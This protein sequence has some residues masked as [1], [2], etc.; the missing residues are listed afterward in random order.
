MTKYYTLSNTRLLLISMLCTLVC[1][2]VLSSCDLPQSLNPAPQTP[3]EATVVPTD[4]PTPAPPTATPLPRGGNLTIRL[5]QDIPFLQPWRPRTR[6]EEQII[7]LMYNGLMKLDETL[8]PQPDLAEKWEASQDGRIITFTIRSGVT[9]HDGEPM[10]AVDVHFTLDRMRALPFTTTA[11]LAD[12]RHISAIATPNRQTIVLSLTERYA[13]LLSEL[14]LPILPRHLLQEEDVGSFNFWDKPI[15]TGPFK[16]ERRDRAHSVIL[17]RNNDYYRGTP[18]LDYVAFVGAVDENLSFEAV[19]DGRLMLAE[20]HWDT[21][22]GITQTLEGLRI[23]GYPENG[24]YFLAFN[25]RQGRPFA[26]PQVRR[27]LAKAIDIPG[28]V[29]SVTKGQGIPIANSAAPGSWA[30]RTPLET[31]EPDLDGARI[32]LDDAGWT[33]ANNSTIRQW[34]GN[35]FQ[36]QIFVRGDDPR[37]IA[38]ARNIAEKAAAIGLQI[39]VQPADF[40]T[41]I[42]SKYAPPYDFDLLL[43][44]W[45]NGAGDPD[46]SDYMYYDPDDFALFHSSQINQGPMDTR[47]TRNIVGFNDPVY[48]DQAN[49]FRQIYDIIYRT[50]ALQQAQARIASLQP[51]LY[52]WADRI[53]V[54]MNERLTTLDGPINLSTPNYLWNIERWHF[55]EN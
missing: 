8:Q 4:T 34:E 3:A 44:S 36:A 18:L 16:F 20:F 47:I 41:V 22:R 12:L 48:D 14:T 35:P 6:G 26:D 2:G 46:F 49:T 55:T 9:W 10:D 38:A 30:D 21:V 29:E 33:I 32:L 31:T 51:Y 54:A 40:E 11:L 7:G 52:L 13:P 39:T 45:S 42:V 15:G 1:I 23:G 27:A 43:G 19:K 50:K 24:F 17:V 37:R 28:L 53:P 25:L 5:K